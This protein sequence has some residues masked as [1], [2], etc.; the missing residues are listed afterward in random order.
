MTGRT[1]EELA[2]G[3]DATLTRTIS[4]DI[5]REYVQAS[6]DG[7]PIH[8]DPAFAAATRFGRIIAP[9][10]LTAGLISAVIGTRL[11]GPGTL[12]LSQNLRFLHPVYVGDVITARATVTGRLPDRN[13]IELATVCVN[14][15][16]QPV[17]EG[18]AWVMPPKARVDYRARAGTPLA[19]GLAWSGLGYAPAAL[20]VQVMSWWVAQSLAVLDHA[21]RAWTS[22]GPGGEPDPIR[23]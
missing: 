3:E 6:G 5:I 4:P 7:N 13:R 17:L 22:S 18:E 11:P 15:N 2:V 21:L 23:P 20:G 19:A 14:Q 8:S 10:M 1:I 9:G 12:Y 16:G